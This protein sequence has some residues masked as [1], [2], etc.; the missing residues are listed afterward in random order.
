MFPI[1]GK[2]IKVIKESRS[3]S[4]I[5][6]AT[7]LSSISLQTPAG[8]FTVPART[9]SNL[10]INRPSP[11]PTPIVNNMKSKFLENTESADSKH[12]KS[13]DSRP[14]PSTKGQPKE[15]DAPFDK[16]KAIKGRKLFF[17]LFYDIKQII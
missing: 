8:S 5:K 12:R 17:L 3:Y 14:V 15:K 1:P 7:A 2:L 10:P 11:S 13:A 6:P 9:P 4:S 16:D